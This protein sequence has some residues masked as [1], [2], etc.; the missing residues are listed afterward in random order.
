MI[1]RI[2]AAVAA[3]HDPWTHHISPAWIKRHPLVTADAK[4]TMGLHFATLGLALEELKPFLLGLAM[5]L[6]RLRDG[7]IITDVVL[8]LI[9]FD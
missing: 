3:V 2:S 6:R 9:T 4:G 1:G 5:T 7:N 8:P